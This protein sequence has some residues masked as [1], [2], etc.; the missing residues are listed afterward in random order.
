[1]NLNKKDAPIVTSVSRKISKMFYV[2][3]SVYGILYLVLFLRKN[4]S[5]RVKRKITIEPNWGIKI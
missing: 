4:E 5:L 3:N 2:V 1:M